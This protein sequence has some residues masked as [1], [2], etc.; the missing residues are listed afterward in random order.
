MRM[1]PGMVDDG[2]ATRRRPTLVQL[3]VV[4][5]LAMT[6]LVGALFWAFVSSSQRSILLG[7]ER[8]RSAAAVRAEAEVDVVL[9]AARDALEDV[10]R[11]IRLGVIDGSDPLAVEARLF[12]AV[13]DDP[14]LAEVTL[15]HARVEG[16]GA[17]GELRFEREGR[18]QVSVLRADADPASAVVTRLARLARVD[19]PGGERFVSE[20]R[21]RPPGGALLDAPLIGAGG[22]TDPTTHLTFATTVL[23]RFYGRMLWSDLHPAEVDLERPEAERR[24]VVTVQKAIEDRHGTFVGVLR[25]G[26]LARTLD[27]VGRLRVDEGAARDPHRVFLCDDHGR[28]VTR[29]DPGDRLKLEGD[30]LRVAPERIPAPIAAALASEPLRRADLDRPEQSG[31]I[32]V[33]GARWLVT[34]RALPGTQG[35]RIGIVVP[36][37]AYVHE[38][39]ALRDRFTLAFL[40]VAVLGATIGLLSLRIV[41]RALG[42]VVDETARMR[43]FELAPATVDAPLRDVQL[44]VDGLERAKT[45]MRALS[46]Y[47]PLDLV[48]RLYADN[49]EP[50]LGGELL[51]VSMMFTDIE[52]FT[53]LAERVSPDELARALGAYLETMTVAI[54]AREGT[55]DKFIGDAVM[56]LWNAPERCAAHARQACRAALDC[57]A[58]TRTL[59]ESPAWHDLP[60]L[61]TRFG[62]HTATV[63]VGHFG[64]PTRL[65]YT[66]LGDGVN[67]GARLEGLCKQYGV[68]VLASEALVAQARD[69]FVFRLVDRVAVKGKHEAIE[70]YELLGAVGDEVPN[71]AVARVYEQ[72]FALHRAREFTA[73]I[74]LL[75][76]QPD[77]GPS[78]TLHARCVRYCAEP[79]DVD[80]D[81]AYVA[82]SK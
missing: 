49:R 55:I 13:V 70:V 65:S 8:L 27:A 36:E 19:E 21:A 42:R 58:A 45:A 32:D 59:Y 50:T 76:A 74:A 57:L 18:W 78:R 80:W 2:I 24:V 11:A 9:G 30:D 5:A 38:L 7:A 61:F 29:L 16:P 69:A 41:R 48:R 47:V 72:A 37:D 53:T 22:A 20:L 26:L 35:W 60:P 79:P 82:R 23:S 51:E 3:F 66:A 31:A 25:V 43:R 6:A 34:F 71:L 46:K 75:A 68:A 14:R 1:D 73:A 12:T 77:D 56:A 40:A 4:S 39:R 67:L 52:G 10:E 44:V 33:G 64:A 63:L 81:G 28:L 15:T 54:E 17:D 62:L